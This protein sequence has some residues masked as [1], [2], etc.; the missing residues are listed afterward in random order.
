[1]PLRGCF[2]SPVQTIRLMVTVIEPNEC[3]VLFI[4]ANTE[5]LAIGGTATV[6][7]MCGL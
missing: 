7:C 3:F 6:N 5:C 4:D 2:R 1:M